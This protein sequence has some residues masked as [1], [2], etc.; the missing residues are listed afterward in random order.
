MNSHSF[1]GSDRAFIPDL[2]PF[3]KAEARYVM[4]HLFIHQMDTL[5]S[6]ARKQALFDK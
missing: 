5:E 6:V 1:A 2:G 3:I 4:D